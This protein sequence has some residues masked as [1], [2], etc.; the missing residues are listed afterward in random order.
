MI[1]FSFKNVS[2]QIDSKVIL[3]NMSIDLNHG[4]IVT[5]I[6]PNGAGKTTF[7]KLILGILN[8]TQGLI[9]RRQPLTMSY[10]PQKFK[11]D[12]TFPMTVKRFLGELE[13]DWFKIHHLMQRQLFDLSGG[14][15]QRILMTKALLKKPDVLV[16][17]EPTQGIDVIGQNIFYET[18]TSFQEQTNCSII[19][20]SHDLHL[21]FSKSHRVICLN[22][23]ICCEGHP[24]Q[25]SENPSYLNLF[26]PLSTYQHKHDHH[27]DL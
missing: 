17:D 16:L 12:S 4:E 11:I 20:V 18:L 5:L 13:D 24:K 9:E 19:L 21:V 23:H 10:V 27:H 14:E 3:E 22:H 8:P 2:F 15:L 6:G 25:V 1:D 26:G 7:I